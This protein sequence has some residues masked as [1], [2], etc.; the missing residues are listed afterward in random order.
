MVAHASATQA[1]GL[2][3]FRTMMTPSYPNTLHPAHGAGHDPEVTI[4]VPVF[5]G[6][7]S[8]ESCIRSILELGYPRGRMEVIVVDNGSTDGTASILDGYRTDVRI[9]RESRRGAGAARNRGILEAR[10]RLIAFTDA[11]CTVDRDW[12]AHLLPPLSEADVGI[13]GGQIL[14]LRP[15][16]R[17]ERFGE[18]IHDHRR[19]IEDFSP[20]YAITMNWASRA[21]VLREV[22]L[23]DAGLMRGQDVNLAHRIQQAGYRLAYSPQA[24]VYHRNERSLFGLFREGF[25]HGH[26]NVRVHREDGAFLPYHRL[27][28]LS[29]WLFRQ[30]GRDVVRGL[31]GEEPFE[32][33][34]AVV[35]NTG[36]ALGQTTGEIWVR[37]RAARASSAGVGGR[38]PL[39]T[40]GHG[41]DGRTAARLREHYEVE[42]RLARSLERADA[43]TRRALYATLYEDLFRAVPDHPQLVRRRDPEEIRRRVRSQLRPLVALLRP[44]LRFLEMGAGDGAFCAELASRVARVYALDVSRSLLT[45]GSAPP[46]LHRIISTAC[47]IPLASQSVDFAYSNQLIEHLHPEDAEVALREAYRV[48]V[49]GGTFV[50][51][52]PSRITGPH[53]ISKYFARVA[54]GFHLKEYTG[55]ELYQAL[56]KGGFSRVRF[57]IWT[58]KRFRR[59]S[60]GT[61]RLVETILGALPFQMR[62]RLGERGLLSAFLPIRVVAEA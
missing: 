12:L 2:R 35:F 19:A 4:V 62:V 6:A 53:D 58:G 18:R 59:V 33:F 5:N 48:L 30:I 61:F 52:T 54:T 28:V 56:A 39:P 32:S 22:G 60:I 15:C 37:L 25:V 38:V 1:R 27:R 34:C 41:D 36:K 20:G 13:V 55:V 11:D 23:F 49:P 9:L 14:A 16:N 40:D 57:L 51:V 47:D 50:C 45:S 46:N 31:K 21:S 29:P 42:R 8:I 43:K 24:R 17:I 7:A 3:S 10:G 44:D 26:H